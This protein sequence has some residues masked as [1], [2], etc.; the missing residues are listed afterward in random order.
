MEAIKYHKKE[1]QYIINRISTLDLQDCRA[2]ANW[3]AEHMNLIEGDNVLC[4]KS[5]Q[6]L[7]LTPR[8][9]KVLRYNNIL[10]IGSLIERASNWD[11]IKMLRGA[12][13]KVLNE[14]SSKITQVQKG[15]IQV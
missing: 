12:G 3:L 11:N 1:V 14:L 5:I 4:Q 9:E 10:T 15:E 2:I 13:A 6:H 8:A 7:N